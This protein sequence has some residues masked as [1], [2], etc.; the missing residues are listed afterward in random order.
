V[1][2]ALFVAE[3]LGV[4]FGGRQVVKSG[5][6]WVRPGRITALMGRNGC[7]KTTLLQAALGLGPMEYGVVRYLDDF[8][9][10]PRLSVM[11]R[12]GLYFLPDRGSLSRRHTVGWHRKALGAQMGREAGTRTLEALG[13]K[14]FLDST[15]DAISGGEARK[16]DLLLAFERA[17]RCLLADEP[18]TG[19]APKDQDTVTGEIRR[20]AQSGAAVLV[21]G[22]QVEPLLALA[23]EVIW[24]TAGSTHHLGTPTEAR[25]HHQFQ[26]EYLAGR[27][28][29]PGPG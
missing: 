25:H 23:D 16:A 20:L 2:D 12:R 11:A 8:Y 28:Q 3:S 7:G 9:L 24:M 17:P 4:S 21:T 18:Y 26:R 14:R 29:S 27:W 22:H 13:L 5:S 10:K 19:V 6:V 15:P 1:K